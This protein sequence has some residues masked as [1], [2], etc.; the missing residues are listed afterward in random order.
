MVSRSSRPLIVVVTLSALSA[1][2]ADPPREANRAEP[3]KTRNSNEQVR[4]EQ[5]ENYAAN[6]RAAHRQAEEDGERALE[7]RNREFKNEN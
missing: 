6:V 5:F 1:S 2:C 4:N 3:I 7:A